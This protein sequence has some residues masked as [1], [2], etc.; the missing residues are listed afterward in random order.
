M[1]KIWAFLWYQ[2]LGFDLGKWGSKKVTGTLI[3]NYT[4]WASDNN[5]KLNP[6][7]CQARQIVV[8]R[9]PHHNELVLNH[10]HMSLKAKFL[11]LWLQ[12]NLK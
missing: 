12:D 9:R 7:K 8:I 10:L 4:K 2:H 6:N 5:L 11:G 1:R 3:N